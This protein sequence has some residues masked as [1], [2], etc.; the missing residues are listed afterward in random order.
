MSALEPVAWMLY[1]EAAVFLDPIPI[2]EYGPLRPL[3]ALAPEQVAVLDAV[4]QTCGT[5][6]APLS[7]TEGIDR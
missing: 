7:S 2:L 6:Y 5:D 1:S 3:Y 4:C